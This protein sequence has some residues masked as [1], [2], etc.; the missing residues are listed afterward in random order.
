MTSLINSKLLDDMLFLRQLAVDVVT[1]SRVK[2][3]SSVGQY[4]PNVTG[5][6]LIRPGGRD[7]YPAFW[8][9]DF[10]MSLGSGLISHEET[11]HA[12]FLTAM[13]QAPE[14]WHTKSG[15][16]VP[17]GSIADHITFQGQPIFFPGTIDDFENQGGSWGRYPSLDDHFYFIEMAWHLAIVAGQEKILKADIDGTSMIKRLDLSFTVP[18][19]ADDS[20]LVWCGEENR[21][22]SFGFTDSVVH[23]GYL[24]FCSLLRYRAARQ[25]AEL[26]QHLQNGNAAQTYSRIADAISVSVPRIFGHG[27]GLLCASTGRSAQPDVWGSAFAVYSGTLKNTDAAGVTRALLH[28]FRNGTISWKG[29]IRHVPT[30]A[31]FSGS[32]AW[33]QVIGN[34]PKNRYQNGAYWNTPTGWVCFAIS[35][36]SEHDAQQIAIDYVNELRDG[37]FRQDDDHGSPYECIHPEN[38][39]RQN[40]VYMT[41]V[42]CP[43]EAFHRLGWLTDIRFN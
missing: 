38:D 37:D 7:C 30:D 3:G 40:P 33:E 16:F 17:R 24:L 34:Y 2:P 32:S 11:T 41:S 19:V 12:L 36:I 39:F 35:Q 8:I 1:A 21:G 28:A 31:D 13:R 23:T 9:R 14:D 6:T 4:G 18:P 10:A 5:K 29:N 20:E 25:M 26:H 27:S 22:V 43:L 42:T 15:S